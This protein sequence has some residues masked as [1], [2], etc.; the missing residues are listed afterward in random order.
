[1]RI[2]KRESWNQEVCMSRLLLLES[3][4]RSTASSTLSAG[5]KGQ[6]QQ[7]APRHGGGVSR[8]LMKQ[9]CTKGSQG[10]SCVIDQAHGDLG[11]DSNSL[12]VGGRVRFLGTKNLNSFKA[13]ALAPYY[14]LSSILLGRS[15]ELVLLLLFHLGL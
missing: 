6:S 11:T 7:K 13:L 14:S 15:A 4:G 8:K 1:M 2:K 12:L 9:Y 10:F 5:G 3:R